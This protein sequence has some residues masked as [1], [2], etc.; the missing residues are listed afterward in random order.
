MKTLGLIAAAVLTAAPAAAADMVEAPVLANSVQRGDI[1]SAADFETAELAESRARGAMLPGDAEG[2]E[3]R[4]NLAA[5]RIVRDRDLVEPRLVRRGDQVSIL[6]GQALKM[7]PAAKREEGGRAIPFASSPTPAVRSMAA[8]PPCRWSRCRAAT[9]DIHEDP[10]PSP[11]R[12]RAGLPACGT[13]AVHVGVPL[14]TTGGS[15]LRCSPPA[16]APMLCAQHAAAGAERIAFPQRRRR[17][18]P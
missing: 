12:R 2:L 13:S 15:A 3:A 16:A 5:G 7:R 17:S 9:G 14:E 18:V 11:L 8:S 1:L 6:V 10:G 4:R